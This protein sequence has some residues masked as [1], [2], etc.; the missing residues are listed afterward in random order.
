MLKRI[1]SVPKYV[2]LVRWMGFGELLELDDCI[3]PRGFVQWV[4]DNVD[5]GGEIIRVGSKMIQ[6]SADAVTDTLG[7]PAG[8]ML[9]DCD[10]VSGKAAFLD[11]FGLTEVPSFRFLGKMILRKDILTDAVF[12]RCFMG[13]ALSSFLCP[14]SS[15]KLSTKYMGALVVVEDISQR[16]WSKIVHEWMIQYIKKYQ[17]EPL[18]EKR[19][20]HTLGGCIY[21][22]GVSVFFVLK[23]LLLLKLL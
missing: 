16:N 4:A 13:V 17:K 20:N 22:L 12:C 18:K 2:C 9:V 21:H 15:T 5:T 10:E 14:N 23:Y 11:V 1:K 19:I 8:E 3:V 6:L 7:T